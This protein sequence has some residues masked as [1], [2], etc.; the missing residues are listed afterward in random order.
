MR[1][2][3][4]SFHA[5]SGH[6]DYPMIDVTWIHLISLLGRGPTRGRRSPNLLETISLITLGGKRSPVIAEFDPATPP[7]GFSPSELVL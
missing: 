1:R 2:Q 4:F 5:D 6:D 7:D 3:P